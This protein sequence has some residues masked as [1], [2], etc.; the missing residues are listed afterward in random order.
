MKLSRRDALRTAGGLALAGLAGCVEERVTERETRITDRAISTLS[1][2][3]EDAALSSDEFDDYVDDM[4]DRYGDG[5]VWGSDADSGQGFERAYVQRHAITHD[6]ARNPTERE[7]VL[8]TDEFDPDAPILIADACLAMYD[9]GDGL[10]R[11]WLW[12]AADSADSR[13]VGNANVDTLSVGLRS[14]NGIL[15]DAVEPVVEDGRATVDLGA[16]PS[17]QFPI[18]E[19]S[20]NTTSVL[21]EEGVYAVMWNGDREGVQSINAVCEE[22]RADEYDLFWSTSLGYRTEETV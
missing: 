9:L 22:E 15:A 19:G 7:L 11:Y 13:L 17:G 8:G 2:Q 20:L 6:T 5:G 14:R 12:T 18:P 1:P 10:Y 16:P 4:V 3:T 21:G